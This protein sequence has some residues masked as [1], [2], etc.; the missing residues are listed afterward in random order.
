[1]FMRANAP[2]T[3]VL[4]LA[5]LSFSSALVYARPTRAQAH[6]VKKSSSASASKKHHPT[7]AVAHHKATSSDAAAAQRVHAWVKSQHKTAPAKK[8]SRLTVAAARKTSPPAPPVETNS[9]AIDTA[10]RQATPQDFLNA[11]TPQ[12]P[13]TGKP[14]T[15]SRP[16]K[17][18]T[19]QHP[20]SVSRRTEAARPIPVV[21]VIRADGQ[22]AH[23]APIEQEAATPSILPSLYNKRGRLIVPPPLKGSREILLR[24]NQVADREGLDRIK[25][26]ED[27]ENMRRENV[28]V[29]LPLNAGM[30][31]DDRLPTN[32]RYCRPW[33]AQFLLGLSRAHYARFHTPLQINSAVR[34]I[35]FQQHLLRINGNAAPAEGDTASP[36]LT[37]QAVDLAKHGLSLTEIAWLRGYL[38]PLVQE[39]KIDVEEE[40]QQSCFHISVYKRYLP[41]GEAPR[42][43]TH[44]TRRDPATSLATA[45]R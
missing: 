8:S 3:A 36:H 41:A 10:H 31:V 23:L 11:A 35:E 44:T 34:T 7:H 39:G 40:F 26:D 2:L 17:T 16:E 13:E 22:S 4:A 37:G 1:M 12:T 24:Q 33:T 6:R 32:R 43:T 27:L 45:I 29:S 30:Q 9:S 42:R 14:E 28:L 20:R 18:A 38:L 25:D 19:R 21:N 5:A 15:P